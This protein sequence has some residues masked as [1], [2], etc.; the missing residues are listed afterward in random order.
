MGEK[1]CR[2]NVELRYAHF[3]RWDLGKGRV[4]NNVELKC[5][6]FA[7]ARKKNMYLFFERSDKHKLL[8]MYAPL[9]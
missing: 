3:W 4:Q 7:T 9:K 6:L 2:N 1:G 8:I 5:T